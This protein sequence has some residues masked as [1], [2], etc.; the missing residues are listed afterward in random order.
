MTSFRKIIE[1]Y[2]GFENSSLDDLFG[3]LLRKD[4]EDFKMEYEQII[5]TCTSF[6]DGS[7]EN[8]YHMLFLG[9]CVY[10]NGD[11][12]VSSNIERGH[13]RADIVLEARHAGS[14]NF[15]IEFKQGEDI[16]QL[17]QEA[18]AQ[19]KDKKYYAGLKGETVLLGIAHNLKACQVVSETKVL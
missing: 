8:A 4:I 15:V 10:L 7:P 6:H 5:L 12:R 19:I 14:P 1:R 11:Y 3:A 18:I 2:G 16:S 17:A 13:G 9:M